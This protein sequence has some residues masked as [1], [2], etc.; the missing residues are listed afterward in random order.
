MWKVN[1]KVTLEEYTEIPSVEHLLSL[2]R[3]TAAVCLSHRQR[4][5]KKGIYIVHAETKQSI[6]FTNHTVCIYICISLCTCT[7]FVSIKYNIITRIIIMQTLNWNVCIMLMHCDCIF[8]CLLPLYVR[9]VYI[10]YDVS[11]LS[12]G[13][14]IIETYSL[15]SNPN[16]SVSSSF[17]P[18]Q[19]YQ[20]WLFHTRRFW[21]WSPLDSLTWPGTRVTCWK[22]TWQVVKR[23]DGH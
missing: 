20:F 22:N 16:F 10:R 2:R 8:Y 13:L 9:Y 17:F 19:K 7:T 15:N 5:L 11:Q 18:N 6:P 12:A 14:F 1:E 21:I 4:S 3:H 23:A